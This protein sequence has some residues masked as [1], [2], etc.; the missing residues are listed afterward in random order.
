MFCRVRVALFFFPS[1]FAEINDSTDV[2]FVCV[3]IILDVYSVT[4]SVCLFVRNVYKQTASDRRL[5]MPLIH[6]LRTEYTERAQNRIL[7]MLITIPKVEYF[8]I[9]ITN[10]VWEWTGHSWIYELQIVPSTGNN[11]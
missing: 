6:I 10:I 3:H 9:P 2:V 1:V 8:L 4:R 5:R 7:F 11:V